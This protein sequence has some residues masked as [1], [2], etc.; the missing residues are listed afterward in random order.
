MKGKWIECLHKSA[1]EV[2]SVSCDKW[3]VGIGDDE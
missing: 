1:M 2:V 3:G